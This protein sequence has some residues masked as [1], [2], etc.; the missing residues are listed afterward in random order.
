MRGLTIS[1]VCV[2][3]LAAA[4]VQAPTSGQES[5]SLSVFSVVAWP[6]YSASPKEQGTAFFINRDGTALTNSHVVEN[7]RVHPR[8]Y[9]LLAIWRGEFYGAALV[10][11]SGSRAGRGPL[12]RDVAEI[13]LIKPNFSF[14][15]ITDHNIPYATAHRGELP[16]FPPLRFGA[17]P[18]VG[19]SVRALGFGN[20]TDTPIPY[21]WSAAGEVTRWVSLSDGI[22]AFEISFSQNA[23]PGHSGS[24]VLDAEGEVVGILTW[25]LTSA[26][27]DLAQ[28][29]AAFDPACR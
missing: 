10:C 28:S 24:P 29:R 26:H 22:R 25:T 5:P 21:E 11:A 14:T 7:V 2:C 27:M 1:L 17:D 15:A 19:Q 3:I 9:D 16:E 6:R 18:G 20:R 23:E 8:E 12:I 4:S 13:R